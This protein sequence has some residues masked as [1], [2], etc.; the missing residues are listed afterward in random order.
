MNVSADTSELDELAADL[1]TGAAKV[2]KVSSVTLGEIARQLQTDAKAAA[3]VDTGALRDS[4]RMSGGRDYRRVTADIRYAI[5]VEF[6]T[7]VMAPQPFMWPAADVA[8]QR[9]SEEFAKLG[10]PFA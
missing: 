6:G 10:D 7:S 4:I 8:E 2:D 9:L 3:P 1:L 5:F